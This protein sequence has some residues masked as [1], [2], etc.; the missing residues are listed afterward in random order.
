M[1]HRISEHIAESIISRDDG[2]ALTIYGIK[3]I[4]GF[5]SHQSM[6]RQTM[7]GMR[8]YVRHLPTKELFGTLSGQTALYRCC[9]KQDINHQKWKQKGTIHNQYANS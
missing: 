7:G 8:I 3:D 9:L 6:P 5:G 4:I 2:K 1:G